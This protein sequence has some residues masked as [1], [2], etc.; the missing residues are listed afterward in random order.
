M[1]Y[2]DTLNDLLGAHATFDVAY[3]AG[4]I[5][6]SDRAHFDQASANLDSNSEEAWGETRWCP[7]EWVLG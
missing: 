5:L 3:N 4:V 6:A 1:G 2:T 7:R